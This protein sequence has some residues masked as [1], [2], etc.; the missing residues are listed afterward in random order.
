MAPPP[1]GNAKRRKRGGR[2][3]KRTAPKGPPQTPQVKVTIR[4]IR[5]PYDSCQSLGENLLPTLLQRANAALTEPTPKMVLD[6]AT[7]QNAI[8]AEQE[9]IAKRE[10]WRKEQLAKHEGEKPSEEEGDQEEEEVKE[11]AE[12][13]GDKPVE[14]TLKVE[15]LEETSAKIVEGI[16]NLTI[17]ENAVT[18][19]VLYMVPPKQTRRRGEKP[20]CVYL[21]LTAPP[22][23]TKTPPP[24]VAPPAQV[25]PAAEEE[26]KKGGTTDE[27]ASLVTPSLPPP[28]ADYS[29]DVARRRLMLQRSVDT[30]IKCAKEDIDHSYQVE[31]SPSAKTYRNTTTNRR[32][33]RLEGTIQDSPDYLQF[34][35]KSQLVREERKARP[36]PAPGGS[37]AMDGLPAS[38]LQ[39]SQQPVAAIVLHLRQKKEEER[40]KKAKKKK[41]KKNSN[42]TP[43]AVSEEGKNKRKKKK[44]KRAQ[45][46]GNNATV[47]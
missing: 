7:V 37:L 27:A 18:V 21:V 32:P 46:G 33:D 14:E 16:E 22:I 47:G 19:R 25:P 13:E 45:K 20:G 31:E 44:K 42:S 40:K 28:V 43:A 34:F 38:S 6:E 24:P 2:N 39:Q 30:L 29:Q 10:A 4:N 11:A 3:R 8:R 15:T 12:A 1:P 9:A 26:S 23:V 5:K 17:D 36:K 35:E 41:N